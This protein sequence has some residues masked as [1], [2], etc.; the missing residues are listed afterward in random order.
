MCRV[1]NYL[2]RHRSQDVGDI[3][4]GLLILLI[5]NARNQDENEKFIRPILHVKHVHA[6]KNFLL[7]SSS[8]NIHELHKTLSRKQNQE[9]RHS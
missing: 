2:R 1:S 8:E 7:V 6:S 3:P 4:T 9:A 5:M